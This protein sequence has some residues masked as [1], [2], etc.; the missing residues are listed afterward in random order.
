MISQRERNRQNDDII[1]RLMVE[2]QENLYVLNAL[3]WK[4]GVK[5]LKEAEG[6]VDQYTTVMKAKLDE[7]ARLK[8]EGK[9]VIDNFISPHDIPKTNPEDQ[10]PAPDSA[11]A[12]EPEAGA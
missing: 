6:I 3:L 5:S 7:R 2:G 4:L 1:K 12:G 9:T 8:A 10:T 11:S